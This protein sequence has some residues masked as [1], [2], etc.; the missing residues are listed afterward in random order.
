L[1]GFLDRFTV[2]HIARSGRW[3]LW[4]CHDAL[5]YVLFAVGLR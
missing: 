3:L 1:G 4:F 2:N 5:W